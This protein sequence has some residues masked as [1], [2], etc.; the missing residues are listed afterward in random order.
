[1][2]HCYVLLVAQIWQTGAVCPSAIIPHVDQIIN[3]QVPD[4][5]RIWAETMSL[6]GKLFEAKRYDMRK[7][8]EK[9]KIPCVSTDNTFGNYCA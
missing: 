9:Q 4:V 2:W 6:S 1:M 5:R 7:T 8:N 3:P